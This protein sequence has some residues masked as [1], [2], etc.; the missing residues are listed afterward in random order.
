MPQQEVFFEQRAGN[1]HIVVLKSYDQAYAREAFESMDDGG[2][3]RLWTSLK[4]EEA[5]DVA[6]LPSLSDSEGDGEAFLWD[7]LLEQARENGP[8]LSFFIVN[9]MVNNNSKSLFVSPDWPTAETFAKT[10]LIAA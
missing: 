9:E 7:E 10:R 5:Y 3:Q 8:V 1:R 4:P 6:D 2:L